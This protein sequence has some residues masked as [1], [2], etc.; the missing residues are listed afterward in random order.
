MPAEQ[1][2]DIHDKE[3]LAIID[4]LKHWRHYLQGARHEVAIITDHKNLTAFTTTKVLNKRQVR[5]AEE[6]SSYNFKISY[7]KGSENQAADALSRRPD[8]MEGIPAK[9]IQI[10][11]ED[12]NG[13]L[14]PNKGIAMAQRIT[15]EWEEDKIWKAYKKDAR[16][17]EL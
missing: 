10:L 17:R 15:I 2:Y 4:V 11:K 14:R 12:D 1:N 8:Y 5:W 13:N 3:L 6:L 7:R 16:A 9:G